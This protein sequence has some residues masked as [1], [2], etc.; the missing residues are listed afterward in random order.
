MFKAHSSH[1]SR[2]ALI[3][4]WF[5]CCCDCCSMWIWREYW[6]HQL[7]I[8]LARRFYHSRLPSSERWTAIT[9]GQGKTWT[10]SLPTKISSSPLTHPNKCS[11][12]RRVITQFSSLHPPSSSGSSFAS[13]VCSRLERSRVQFENRFILVEY[14]CVGTVTRYPVCT[15]T[16]RFIPYFFD[17]KI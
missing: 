8:V 3:E 7:H 1:S 14:C 17:H 13:P 5:V 16:C 4:I 12:F 9:L 11:K 2:A 15:F 6:W 10:S